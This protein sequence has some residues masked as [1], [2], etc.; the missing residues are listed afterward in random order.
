MTA[1]LPDQYFADVYAASPD[2]WRLAERWYEQR[3]YAITTAMLPRPRY[4]HAF[5]PGC[6]VGVLTELLAAR[7][8]AV[9]ATDVAPAALDAARE[10]LE[11]A[12]L[13]DGVE[14]AGRSLD[15]DW[16]TGVDLVVVS[17]VAYYLSAA[18]FREVLDRECPRLGTGAT[19]V[20]AHWR[21]PVAD[22]PMTGDEVH[23]LIADTADLHRLGR[24][25]DDDVV[26][27]VFVTGTAVSVATETGVPGA[28]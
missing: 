8:D 5:E 2:P 28:V 1:R 9:T 24:Y 21:H 3:K 6:S 18:T 4:R 23:E 22:Y 15:D 13:A 26:I 20:A 16:P 27:E 11:R 17:E 12:G 14:F 7:C 10:R 25:R 19:L